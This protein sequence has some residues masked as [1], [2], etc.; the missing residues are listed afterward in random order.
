MKSL[1][2]QYQASAI[3]EPEGE[4][5]LVSEGVDAL[6]SAAPIEFGG[7]GDRW[8]PETLL[9]AAIADCFILTF[10]A[11]ASAMKLTWITLYCNVEGTLDRE[12]G[13]TRFTEF[14]VTARLHVLPDTDEARAVIL[15]Q[16]AKDGCF[17]ANSL[18]ARIDFEM[19]ITVEPAT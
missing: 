8:S 9:A 19:A 16:K 15:L 7:P 10:R 11:V 12:Q 6:A 13:V 4:V 3:A 17:I 18:S 14:R 2:H 5:S 1:P